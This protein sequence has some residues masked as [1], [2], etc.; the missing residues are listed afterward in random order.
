[1]NNSL[2]NESINNDLNLQEDSFMSN[3]PHTHKKSNNI[4]SL[5]LSKSNNLDTER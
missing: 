5:S 2:F 1:M 4:T 3:G